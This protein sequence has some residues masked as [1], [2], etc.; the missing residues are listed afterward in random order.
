MEYSVVVTPD[1]VCVSRTLP[2]L[3]PFLA[4][5]SERWYVNEKGGSPINVNL[6]SAWSPVDTK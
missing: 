2:V 3:P 6:I 4:L 5:S 1:T